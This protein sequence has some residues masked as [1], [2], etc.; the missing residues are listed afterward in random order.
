M[1]QHN[2]EL[3]IWASCMIAVTVVV[4]EATPASASPVNEGGTPQ[5]ATTVGHLVPSIQGLDAT[6]KCEGNGKTAECDGDKCGCNFD[7]K[8][9]PECASPPPGNALKLLNLE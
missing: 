7:A 1:N 2:K 9:D 6:C 8:G 3:A 4:F 5:G